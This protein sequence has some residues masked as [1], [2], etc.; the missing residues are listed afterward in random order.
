VTV[1]ADTSGLLAV[2]DRA[3][4]SHRRA[5]TTWRKLI[6]SDETIVTSNYILIELVALAQRRL[7]LDAVRAI[8]SAVVPSLSVVWVDESLH[9]RATAAMLTASRRALSLVDCS[10]FEIMRDHGIETAFA[11][12]RDF[13]AQGFALVP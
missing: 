5:A 10:S 11:L 1:F 13:A 12:D 3:E 6:E 2:L 4:A 9:R 7:G 8:E